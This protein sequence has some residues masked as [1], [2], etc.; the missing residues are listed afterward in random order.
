MPT[1][2]SATS[3][4][5][6]TPRPARRTPDPHRRRH[7]RPP[8]RAGFAFPTVRELPRTPVRDSATW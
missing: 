5:D 4:A 7:A 6:R 3:A 8:S 2:T 1:K